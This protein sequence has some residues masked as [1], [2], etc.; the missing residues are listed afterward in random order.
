MYYYIK[1][2][3][4]SWPDSI[5]WSPNDLEKEA[6]ERLKYHSNAEVAIYSTDDIASEKFLK[7]TKSCIST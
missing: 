3:E 1:Y 6:T 2:H 5:Y 7:L 4:K